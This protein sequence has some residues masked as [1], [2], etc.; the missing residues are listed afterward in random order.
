[1]KKLVLGMPMSENEKKPKTLEE[2]TE[3][4]RRAND[5]LEVAVA[6]A[7]EVIARVRATTEKALRRAS[8]RRIRLA[9]INE[10]M[11]DMEDKDR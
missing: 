1:V 6:S 4:M 10:A 3:A 5:R 8:M 7:D 2:S 9:R 11:A